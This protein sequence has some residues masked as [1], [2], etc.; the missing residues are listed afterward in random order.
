MLVVFAP[1]GIFLLWKY[2]RFSKLPRI[3]ISAVFAIFFLVMAF[4]N[5]SSGT[6]NNQTRSQTQVSDQTANNKSVAASL[7]A[8]IVAL[9]ATSSITLD[10]ADDV[11]GLRTE[12]NKLTEEQKSY[13]KNLAL[14]TGA[15]STITNLQAA[16]DKAAADKVA[17]EQAAAEKATAEQAA[18]Q[19]TSSSSSSSSGSSSSYSGSSSGHT[20]YEPAQ[21]QRTVYWVSGGKSYHYDKNCSTLAR[22]KNILSGPA[23]ECPKTDPCD[24]C[25]H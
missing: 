3:A 4:P 16:A 7:D 8:R 10:K 22:S 1:V 9:G 6:T 11:K 5:Q 2:N 24:K 14:L 17:A 23:S 15:E 21:G 20:T 18:S 12:Y 13:I 19:S 25:V